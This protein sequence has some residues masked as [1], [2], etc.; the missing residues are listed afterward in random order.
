MFK[1]FKKMARK[2]NKVNARLKDIEAIASLATGDT[3]KFN[4]RIKN[5]AKWRLLWKIFRKI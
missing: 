4:R 2:I 3:K 1:E 5:K